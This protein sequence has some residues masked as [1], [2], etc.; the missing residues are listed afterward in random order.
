QAFNLDAAHLSLPLD[1]VLQTTSGLDADYYSFEISANKR[2]TGRW[3]MV[4]SFAETWN[5]QGVANI[6]PN[7]E[8]NEIDGR[9]RFTSWQG[10]LSG[11]VDVGGGVRVSPALRM[12]S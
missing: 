4:A 12:Q 2:Q 10:K 9:D 11:N 7:A 6:T 3:G 1:Q 8:I 5:R